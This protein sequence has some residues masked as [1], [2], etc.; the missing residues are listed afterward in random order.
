MEFAPLVPLAFDITGG[1]RHLLPVNHQEIIHHAI[2]DRQ[3]LVV[4]VISD[5]ETMMAAMRAGDVDV[6][7]ECDVVE[8]RLDSLGGG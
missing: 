8:L 7:K 3:P 5:R 4:G 6:K 2:R 1:A